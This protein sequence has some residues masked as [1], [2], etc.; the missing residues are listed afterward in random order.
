MSCYKPLIR[1][2][3]PD[4][5]EQGGRVYSLARL[6]QLSG[7]QLKYEDL[8][9]NPKVMLIPCGQCIGC[10]IRQRED[11]T[12]R[13]ELEARDYPKE[14]VWFITLT[15]DDDHVPGM[16][17]KTGEIMRKVQYTWKPGEKR[18]SSV[19]IL[20]YE[21]IQKFLKRL[22][23]AYRG[24]LRYFVAGE[25]GEQTARP[26]YH[27]IL[28]GW[29]P[30]D[31]ENLYKI[32]HNG[33][34]TSKWLT[35]LWG[36]GQIQIAQAV[37][38]T[39]RYVAGYVTKKMYEI[40]GQKAN[41][42]YELGQTKPFACM[43]LKPGL[44]DHYYQEHKAEIWRQGYIQCTNGKQAQIPRYYEKQMEAE[45]PQ[46]LWRIKQN[47]QKNAMEQKR[48]QLE[49]QDYKTVLETKERVTKKQTKKRGIL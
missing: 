35:D 31:L 5:R 17:V 26:H 40:N 29:K 45:N 33:Y 2:Y 28:Y 43:S 4:N 18:P 48:L 44:G 21:D 32:R 8:M 41:A 13:I 38:E 20:L 37:P 11:W 23:K 14:E 39:Y 1:L 49:G 9:Y 15:Y 42:Y 27:M 10:R 16:I 6:S 22:R 12:T 46:R 34:Y 24:K 7:K 25:Y 36:M 47:R 30:T 19:Q 3:N